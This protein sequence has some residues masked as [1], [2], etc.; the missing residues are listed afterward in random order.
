MAMEGE[1]LVDG[2]RH[3][4]RSFP[5]PSDEDSARSRVGNDHGRHHTWGILSG[6]FTPTE[7]G[8]VAVV[9]AFFVT[10]SVCR[11]VKWSELPKL[12]ARVVRRSGHDHDR[13]RD[14]ILD[15]QCRPRPR[16][17]FVDISNDEFMFLLLVNILR[18]ALGTFM[19]LAPMLL[20]CTPI[21]LPVIKKFGIDPV[22]FGDWPADA[23]RGTNT[24]VDRAIGRVMALTLRLPS[25][26]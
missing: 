4:A 12:I 3:R 25:E 26:V 15:R 5:A 20:I 9:Y 24:V 19:N 7:A 13:D 1:V 22:H 14:R 17:F 2:A 18:L 23:A 8:A 11:D 6:V 21:F 16:S 10:M